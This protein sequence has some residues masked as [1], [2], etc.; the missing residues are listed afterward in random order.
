[1]SSST[2]SFSGK[3][4]EDEDDTPDTSIIYSPSPVIEGYAVAEQV[5]RRREETSFYEVRYLQAK[6]ILIQLQSELKDDLKRVVYRPL[7]NPSLKKGLVLLPEE[8]KESSFSEVFQEGCE[9]A[10]S[11][12]DCEADRVD[13]VKFLVAVA[14]SS[15][16]LD[17]FNVI[18]PGMGAFAPIIALRGPSGSGKDRLLNALRLN[19]Y[20]PFY[21]VSTRRV[22]SLYRPLDQWRG[23]LCLSEMD[24]VNTGETSELTHYL[25]CRCYGVPISRQN[26]DSP[27]YNEV[28]H[29]FGLTIITQ[30]RV[31]EDN[32]LEDR[33]IPFYCEKSQKA[34]PTEELDDWIKKGLDLQAK[35]LYLRL[36]YWDQVV[37]DK[38]A[39]VPGIRDHRLTA[40]VLPLLAIGKIEPS[41][42]SNIVDILKVLEKRRR[43]V[44]AM[45]KDGIII[46]T[47]YEFWREN[48][49][50]EHNGIKYFAKNKIK[51]PK[52]NEDL[53]VPLQ[54]SDLAEQIRWST[55]EVRNVIN[56]LQFH[57]R[58]E[59]LPKLVRIDRVYR[60][61]WFDEGRLRTR[62]MEFVPDYEP[63]EESSVTSVTSVTDNV[64]AAD[65]VAGCVQSGKSVTNVTSVTEAGEQ[66]EKNSVEESRLL[67]CITCG[68]GPWRDPK[69]A[70]EHRLLCKGHDIIEVDENVAFLDTEQFLGRCRRG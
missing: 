27:K 41:F 4:V 23:T 50:G 51:H 29:N 49:M 25:N 42:A 39:R 26:P 11:M 35:L 5:Y 7:N 44:K 24:F 38:G 18:V 20:R 2:S 62:F 6:S 14:Q 61:I 48:L 55:R 32:A 68:A 17:K 69:A 16:F 21:D 33:T 8:V 30:R 52:T 63:T 1:M 12:Y 15:W 40:A 67:R 3:S 60:P 9:L 70:K 58:Q 10:L 56:S 13:E 43:E 36:R 59:Q 28:F 64:G 45:S 57:P 22:P 19:C 46:N 31:W 54:T 65:L 66:R 47:L 53:F 34:I 37:I